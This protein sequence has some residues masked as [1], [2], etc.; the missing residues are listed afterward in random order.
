MAVKDL[1]RKYGFSD[2]AFYKWRSR[3]G[4]VEVSDARRL[5]EL[6]AEK[7]K[8]KKLL[9]GAHLDVEALKVDFGVK[10]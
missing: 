6:E 8:L 10:R 1:C 4:G 9:T 7:R 3:L 5:R 2:A